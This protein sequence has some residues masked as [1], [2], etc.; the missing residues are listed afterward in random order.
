[1]VTG[2]EMEDNF[3]QVEVGDTDAKKGTVD[4]FIFNL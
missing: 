3:R 4:G 2:K 1:M